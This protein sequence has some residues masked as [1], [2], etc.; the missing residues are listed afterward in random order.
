MKL[1]VDIRLQKDWNETPIHVEVGEEIVGGDFVD[2][3][4]A[5][6]L[7]QAAERLTA[8]AVEKARSQIEKRLNAELRKQLADAQADRRL[9]EVL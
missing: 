7:A 3:V 4:G 6:T 1:S 9:E 2:Q 8:E 5:D